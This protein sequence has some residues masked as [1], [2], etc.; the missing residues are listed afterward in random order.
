MTAIP[1]P[2]LGAPRITSPGSAD[3]QIGPVKTRVSEAL[4]A[5]FEAYAR[6]SSVVIDHRYGRLQQ[7][8]W[9]SAAIVGISMQEADLAINHHE[10]R[11]YR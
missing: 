11:R 3:L 4:R 10:H 8:G 9:Q 5:S 7:A 2:V 6:C 1:W